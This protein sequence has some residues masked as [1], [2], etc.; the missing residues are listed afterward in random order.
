MQ[1]IRFEFWKMDMETSRALIDGRLMAINETRRTARNDR[2]SWLNGHFR[3]VPLGRDFPDKADAYFGVAS[4][5]ASTGLLSIVPFGTVFSVAPPASI[6]LV[7]INQRRKMVGFGEK[8][9]LGIHSPRPTRFRW[10]KML[11]TPKPINYQ[12]WWNDTRNK[13]ITGLLFLVFLFL[14]IG[15]NRNIC[16]FSKE[17]IDVLFDSNKLVLW[18]SNFKCSRLM[19]N[20]WMASTDEGTFENHDL[21]AV[22]RP[23]TNQKAPFKTNNNNKRKK[24]GTLM[25]A[26][27]LRRCSAVLCR[28]IRSEFTVNILFANKELSWKSTTPDGSCCAGASPPASGPLLSR[29]RG[30]RGDAVIDAGRAAP[31]DGQW[32][33]NKKRRVVFKIMNGVLGG[34]RKPLHF[35]SAIPFFVIVVVRRRLYRLKEHL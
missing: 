12:C 5:D 6:D 26:E 1:Q 17:T 33:E 24:I 4:F 30:G 28:S 20:E 10:E 18:F 7:A 31:L 29:R 25:A 14:R 35:S 34:L 21:R 23:T 11:I 22:Q 13:T 15:V 9:K 19:G 16:Y 8:I 32:K 3:R 2:L 27:I